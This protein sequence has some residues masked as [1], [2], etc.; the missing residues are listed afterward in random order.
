[1]V[2]RAPETTLRLTLAALLAAGAISSG[3]GGK[4]ATA[5]AITQRPPQS[6]TWQNL[7]LTSSFA[8]ATA[9]ADFGGELLAGGEF[10]DAAGWPHSSF[11]AWNG[12]L[13]RLA[14]PQPNSEILALAVYGD[15]LYAGGVFT[16]A[17]YVTLNHI[18]AWDGNAWHALG[19]GMGWDVLALASFGSDLVAGG[20]FH[21]AGGV[22]AHF[23][24]AWN[25]ATWRALGSGLDDAVWTLTAYRGELIAGGAFQTAGGVPAHYVAAWNGTSWHSLGGASDLNGVVRALY[26]HH[27]T[28]FAGGHFTRAGGVQAIHVACWAGARWDSVGAGLGQYVDEPVLSFSSYQDHLVAGGA[29]SGGTA[30]WKA[31]L[32]SPMGFLSGEVDALA[33]SGA[34]LYAGGGF[35]PAPGLPQNGVTRWVP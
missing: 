1:M 13:W 31:G 35:L 23:V 3:C 11:V 18:G 29:F 30:E 14:G 27:D 7:H 12:S 21:D 26:V 4:S 6:G 22:T 16:Q 33:V 28:L 5:P 34:R 9:L 25:G 24:A 32:W 19:T 17:G 8:S 2:S 10:F 15:R 20:V